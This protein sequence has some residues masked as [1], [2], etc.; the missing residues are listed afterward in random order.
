M[1]NSNPGQKLA[2]VLACRI[3]LERLLCGEPMKCHTT[4]QIGGPAD[5]LVMPA[6]PEEASFVFSEAEKSSVPITVIGNG[7]NLLVRDK[8]I[9]GLVVKFGPAMAEIQHAGTTV[10]AGGGALLSDVAQYAAAQNLTGMEF[11]VGIP[12]SIGGAVYMNAGAY[13]GEM[14]RIVTKVTAVCPEGTIGMYSRADL[15][16]S[17]RHSVFQAN[18]CVICQV[19]LELAVGDPVAIESLMADL[20]CK[21][22]DKQPLEFPSAG[23][24][25]K[26]PSGFFAG[27]LIEQAGCK[28]LT[29]GGA[30]VSEKHAGFLINTGGATATDVLQLIRQVQSIVKARFDVD[31]VPE[32]IVLGEE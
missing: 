25:F 5:L 8:G 31:L 23:S 13:D 15:Q 27:T 1:A 14:S 7:S 11:A 24:T 30:Q 29:V 10:T 3:P 32:V 6:T 19:E 22:N 18:R 9:R 21:R 2:E 28:G 17:Y 12:G 4:F 26:R 20:T 16:F